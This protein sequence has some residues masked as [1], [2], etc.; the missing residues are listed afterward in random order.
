MTA[1]IAPLPKCRETPA[2]F[3]VP[4]GFEKVELGPMIYRERKKRYTSS[5]TY[6]GIADFI[7]LLG[8]AFAL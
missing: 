6:D 7:G 2:W 8:N 1:T 5:L 3:F 4:S